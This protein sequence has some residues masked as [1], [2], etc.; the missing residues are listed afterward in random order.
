MKHYQA[1]IKL[2]DYLVAEFDHSVV[3]HGKRS[4]QVILVSSAVFSA[5]RTLNNDTLYSLDQLTSLIN[6]SI[7]EQTDLVIKTMVNEGLLK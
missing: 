5:L 4:D 1:A 2:D 7:N 6:L 3:L